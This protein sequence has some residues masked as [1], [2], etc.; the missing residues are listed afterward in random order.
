MEHRQR[1]PSWQV[2]CG[3][4]QP[5]YKEN[6]TPRRLCQP[7][8]CK[9]TAPGVAYSTYAQELRAGDVYA[10]GHNP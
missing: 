9:L 1:L 4:P 7:P 6:T 3:L 8:S 10:I 5:L 2:A